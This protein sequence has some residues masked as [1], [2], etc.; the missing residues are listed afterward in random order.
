[1][2]VDLTLLFWAVTAG[3]CALTLW[4]QR[5]I[6]QG[7]VAMLAVFL[8]M[9]A[10]LRWPQEFADY[11]TQKE[12]RLFSLTALSAFAPFVLLQGEDERRIFLY[13][14][15]LLGVVMSACAA[16]EVAIVGSSSR[17]GIFNTNPI[18][19]A[20]ASGFAVIVLFLLYWQRHINVWVF[21]PLAS[22]ALLG[23][24]ASGSRGPLVAL[25][26]TIIGT[27][28]LCVSIA[29]ERVWSRGAVLLSIAGLAVAILYLRSG[30][31][32]LSERFLRLL[33]GQW[34]NTEVSRWAVWRETSELIV[35][36]PLGVGWGRLS[37]SVQV[38]NDGILLRHPHNIVL[39]IAV[40]AGWPAAVIFS[41]LVAGTLAVGFRRA[42]DAT[43]AAGGRNNSVDGLLLFSAPA[44]W[45][46]CALFSG[47][48]NDNRPFW[49]MLGMALAAR[50]VPLVG[51]AAWVGN[52]RNR[53][54]Y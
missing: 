30:Y 7:S 10:G 48:V 3:F 42:F 18:L 4:R 27:L 29:R 31:T 13:A 19:L 54:G 35:G 1:M 22:L 28:P 52:D 12:I 51:R 45:L 2:P 5:R 33:T 46:L 37:E 15:A 34:G 16:I 43:P 38:Y 6:P 24:L 26:A 40:E 32:R 50:G 20:R 41:V 47:D 8:A 39:E 9:A 11:E 25:L 44:Y 14:I 53:G 23:L 49:A 36:S 17:L 21:L